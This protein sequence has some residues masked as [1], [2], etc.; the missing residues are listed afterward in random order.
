MRS[1][2]DEELTRAVANSKTY[3][4]VLRAIGLQPKGGNTR[5]IKIHIKRL[6]LDTSHFHGRGYRPGWTKLKDEEVFKRDSDYN[7]SHLYSRLLKSG[8]KENKC[9]ECGVVDWNGKP[10]R[11]HVD[12]INGDNRDHR[13]ENLRLLC[14]N[15]HSQTPT[16]CKGR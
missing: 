16:Y 9:E 7:V 3:A 2:T 14:P 6:G 4:D 8:L 12:H 15:C 13:V 5:S 1:W 11:L 10:L